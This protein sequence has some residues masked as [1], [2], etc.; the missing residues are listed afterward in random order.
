MCKASGWDEDEKEINCESEIYCPYCGEKY[1]DD[2]QEYPDEDTLECCDCKKKFAYQ[3]AVEV[4]YNSNRD[5]EL[6]GEKH[7]YL[8]KDLN[9]DGQLSWWC[10]KCPHLMI[11]KPAE[12]LIMHDLGKDS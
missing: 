9:K 12:E 11:Q 5:C 8:E 4:T 1:T 7:E 10:R 6:N 2:S 3:R